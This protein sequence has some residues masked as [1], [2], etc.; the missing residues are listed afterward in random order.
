MKF[1]LVSVCT[2]ALIF[3][4]IIV[5][6]H[7]VSISIEFCFPPDNLFISNTFLYC[8][9]ACNSRSP[10]PAHQPWKMRYPRKTHNPGKVEIIFN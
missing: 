8:L 9:S 3:G 2:C 6:T 5:K 10:L 7:A 1:F 4:A